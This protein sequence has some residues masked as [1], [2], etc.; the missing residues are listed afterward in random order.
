LGC[1]GG[2]SDPTTTKT[3]LGLP[4]VYVLATMNGQPLPYLAFEDGATELTWF[5]DTIDIATN[6]TFAER[7][8]LLFTETG[9]PNP[10]PLQIQGTWT[11]FGASHASLDS[12]DAHQFLDVAFSDSGL[13]TQ[14]GDARNFYARCARC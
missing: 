2:A 11:Q 7:R 3:P 10:L 14:V 5:G 13:D 4:G 1:D 12:P 8:W 9:S 6:G